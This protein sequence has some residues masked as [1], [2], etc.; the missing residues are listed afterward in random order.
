MNP[1]CIFIVIKLRR[2]NNFSMKELFEARRL[3]SPRPILL[4][5]GVGGGN[6]VIE[7]KL[8]LRL[9][10]CLPVFIDTVLYNDT[11]CLVIEVFFQYWMT[12]LIDT[13]WKSFY[14]SVYYL[15]L[16]CKLHSVVNFRNIYF[17]QV[18]AESN[19][20]KYYRTTPI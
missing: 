13:H 5:R 6:P 12:E 1:V 18:R 2:F 10:I 20:P 8:V 9:P 4:S 17:H 19:S 7:L 3:S 16:N 14:V 15:H 11:F